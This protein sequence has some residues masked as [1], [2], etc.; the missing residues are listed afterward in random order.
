MIEPSVDFYLDG[1]WLDKTTDVRENPPI[2]ITGG[3]KDESTSASPSRCTFTMNNDNGDYNPRDPLGDY[4]GEL[5]KNTPI[6][7]RV[8]L[9]EDDV[10][11]TDTD[12]WG[13]NW[14]NAASLGGTVADTDWT[15]TGTTNVHHIPVDNAYRR[16]MLDGV[17]WDCC[18]K[19]RLTLPTNNVAGGLVQSEIE[20]GYTD[21]NNYIAA[22]FVFTTTETVQIQVSEVIAGV[23]RKLLALTT[24]PDLSVLIDQSFEIVALREGQVIRLK[25]WPT[26]DPEPVDWLYE[27]SRASVRY[28]PISVAS[29]V[30]V[31]NSNTKPFNFTY[32][33]FVVEGRPFT[34]EATEFSPGVA[35]HSHAAPYVQITASG[36]TQRTIQGSE[37]LDSAMKRYWSSSRRWIRTTFAGANLNAPNNN[38]FRTTDAEV[39]GMAVGQFFR[40]TRWLDGNVSDFYIAREDQMF[41][42]TG[43]SSSGGNT[44][45]TFTPD[46]LAP[47]LL[48]DTINT[49]M[50]NTDTMAP[51][52]YW[53]CED[54]K[55]S[56]QIA[57]GLVGGQ[58]MTTSIAVPKYAESDLFAGSGPILKLNNAELNGLVPDYTDTDQAFTFH[59]FY[60]YP[61]DNDSGHG[62]AFVQ[63]WTDS[64][65]AEV[66]V[67]NFS[68]AGADLTMDIQAIDV[69]GAGLLFFH[70][71]GFAAT[72]DKPTMLVLYAVQ[73]APTT[74]QYKLDYML[75]NPDGTV[76]PAASFSQTTA[77]GVTKLGKLKKIQ[78]NPGGGYV[79][80]AV[81]HIGVVGTQLTVTNLRDA[82][83]GHVGEA[84]VR[85]LNRMAYE[86]DVPLTYCQGLDSTSFLGPQ[87]QATLLNNWKQVAEFDLGRFYEARGAYSFV[88][89]AR[90]SLYNQ[91]YFMDIDYSNGGVRT[92]DTA[93]DDQNTRN[94]ITVKQ[95]NGSSYRAVDETGPL[96]VLPPGEGG[97]GRYTDAPEVNTLSSVQLPDLAGWRLGLGT[98]NEERYPSTVVMLEGDVTL[99]Q[100]LSCEVGNRYRLSNLQARGI[101]EP[102]DQLVAGY[103]LTLHQYVPTLEIN[104]TPSSIYN[105]A[106]L[107]DDIRLDSDDSQLYAAIDSTD[108]TFVVWNVTVGSTWTTDGAEFPFDITVG[109]ERMTVTGVSG[110]GHVLQDFTVTRSVNGVVKSH[111]A[112][113]KVALSNP[114]YLPL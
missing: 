23:T 49:Y 15:R 1:D 105:V 80:T 29:V 99:A 103:V 38:T 59:C 87:Q 58:P 74:V 82:P 69:N 47:V 6:R 104:G 17:Y 21:E 63:L 73:T 28:G 22:Q 88:Y 24:V 112:N 34:G 45:I 110:T 106:E 36:I 76:G 71:Y 102:I 77:T 114:V 83:G 37:P 10:S 55:S 79:E 57:S 53:P 56:A 2:K 27:C 97:V 107:D 60:H 3:V 101:Y 66:W 65:S 30:S 100:M 9:L 19:Y 40:L 39:V 41:T 20:F 111:S 90:S 50:F 98:I 11:E 67:I 12:G 4:F 96:S 51:I 64:S 72:R 70:S 48:Y 25:I 7:V 78:V 85:R 62:Q 61:T 31:S 109:G 33:N 81:G 5:G 52:A 16:S 18:V 84:P 46:A 92:L 91:T 68:N 108:S 8:P 86:E 44:T 54:G 42:I 43:M 113:T 26:G 13:A 89:R 95:L 14:S 35:D 32:D 94:D 93:D 75:Y